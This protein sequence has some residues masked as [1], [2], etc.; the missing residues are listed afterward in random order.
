MLKKFVSFEIHDITKAPLPQNYD[1]IALLNVLCHYASKGRERV[2]RNI[3][4]SLPKDGWLICERDNPGS[5]SGVK[6][7]HKYMMDLSQH[8]FAKQTTVI[9]TW[10]SKKED[11][12]CW[13]RAYIKA[14]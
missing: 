3:H 5:A 2:L 7:Y 1:V 8:G 14:V 12:S 11:V 13:S 10:F 6:E 9:P 4:Q